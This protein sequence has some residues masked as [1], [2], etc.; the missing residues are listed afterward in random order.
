MS[1]RKEAELAAGSSRQAKRRARM[2]EIGRPDTAA[3]DRAVSEAFRFLAGSV[4][5]EILAA[6]DD[7]PKDRRT[8]L[9]TQAKVRALDVPVLAVRI[10]VNRYGYDRAQTLDAMRVRQEEQPEHSDPSYFPSFN[11][12]PVAQ[13]ARIETV[14][15]ARRLTQD[16]ESVG[17]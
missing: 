5:R 10:L 11:P 16:S 14:R 15:Q 13:A 12:D 7:M 3:I 8:E 1:K 6:T 17:A 4:Q 2:A 9:L